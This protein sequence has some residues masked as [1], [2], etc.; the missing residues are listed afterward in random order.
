M[1]NANSL[2]SMANATRSLAC[3]DA[4][5]DSIN[6]Y[7]RLRA[8]WFIAW[9]YFLHLQLLTISSMPS[10]VALNTNNGM[11][12]VSCFRILQISRRC[13]VLVIISQSRTRVASLRTNTRLV[14]FCRQS[15]VLTRQLKQ[16]HR[17]RSPLILIPRECTKP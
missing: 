5:S 1:A 11:C 3:C 8:W 17:G 14:L 7:T 13:N 16:E 10:L 2:M 12:Y 6:T 9:P 4:T 15:S